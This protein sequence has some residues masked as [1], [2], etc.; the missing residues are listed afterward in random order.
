VA[1][2][3]LHF[4]LPCAVRFSSICRCHYHLSRRWCFT[5]S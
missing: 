2:I 4:Y 3:F 1:D 5:D